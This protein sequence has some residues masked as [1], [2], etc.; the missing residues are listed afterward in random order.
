ME[1]FIYIILTELFFI[2][3]LT[4]IFHF[5][6]I[7]ALFIIGMTGLCAGLLLLIYSGGAFSIIGFS[8]RRFHYIMAPKSVK[9]TMDESSDSHKSLTIRS[10]K[11]PIT[12]PLI[13]VSTLLLTISILLLIL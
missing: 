1:K 8:F 7:N 2:L 4:F 9:A 12:S 10:E 3:L 6:F 5:S 13:I 11:Y